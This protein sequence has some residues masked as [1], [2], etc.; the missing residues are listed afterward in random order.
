[1]KKPEGESPMRLR[2]RETEVVSIPIPKD[3][4]A[5]LKEVAAQREMSYEALLKLYI[6]QGLWQDLTRFF[7]DRVLETTAHVLARHLQ[8]EAEVASI[9]REIREEAIGKAG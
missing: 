6:G 4:L 3:T 2:P 8:S 7:G 5:S 1:M 9:M